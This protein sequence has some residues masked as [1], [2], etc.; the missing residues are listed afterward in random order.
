MKVFLNILKTIVA[1]PLSIVGALTLL[2]FALV[3]LV[4][5]L[6]VCVLTDIWGD[7]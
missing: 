5:E 3:Y 7:K 2:P 1:L 6:P 4:I